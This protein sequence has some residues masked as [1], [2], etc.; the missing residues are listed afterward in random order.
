MK[1]LYL[2]VIP[3][4]ICSIILCT[5]FEYKKDVEAATDAGNRD[6]LPIIIIDA[7]HGGIDGGA[8]ADDG[9]PE[10]DINLKIT[11]HLSEFLKAFGFETV[12]T[13]DC[14][15][16]LESDG[17]NTIR[18]KKTSDIHN[19]L[20]LMEETD[21]AL[22]ISIHQNHFYEEQYYGTQVFYSPDFSEESSLLAQSIQDSVTGLLQPDNDRQIKK[23]GTSV[24]LIY[25]AVKPAVLVECGFLSNNR[26]AEL[27]KTDEYQRKIAFGIALGI[28]DYVYGA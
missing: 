26:E 24:Y 22:F 8:Q 16:S 4:L 2:L 21:N 7:G 10:K 25:N 5:S 15:K 6:S 18:E 14:D 27:L 17:F 13:R 19:R 1:K 20:A 23:C 9:T 28:Q 12:L 11:L 3:I